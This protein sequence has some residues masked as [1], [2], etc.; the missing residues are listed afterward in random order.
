ML[1]FKKYLKD[2]SDNLSLTVAISSLVLTAGIGV[3]IETANMSRV[4]NKLQ[5]QVDIATLNAA[6]TKSTGQEDLNYST[7]AF[8]VMVEKGYSA[9][10]AKPEA[11]S[12]GTY[13]D[14]NV[15]IDY[16]GL[17]T[18]LLGGKSYKLKASAQ[19]TLPG[20]APLEMVLALDNTLSMSQ[21]GKM[22]ALKTGAGKIIDAVEKSNSGT[23][24]GLVPFARYVSVGEASG[25]WLD[26][27]AEY[28]T[29]RTW[30][31]ATHECDS[32][33]YEDKTEIRDGVAYTYEAEICNGRTTTYEPQ[34]TIVESR[35]VGCVGT[36]G[37]PNHLDP[38]SSN[39]RVMGL[40]NKQPYE[41]TGLPWDTDS[42]CPLPIRPLD[43]D[44]Y[45][46]GKHIN[47]MYPTDVTYIPLGLLWAERLLDRTIAYTQAPK[48]EAKQQ[49]M[50]LMSDGKNTSEIRDDQ[51]YED[52]LFSPPYIFY[53]YNDHNINV[54]SA[55]AD[56]SRLCERMKDKG[57]VIY[58]ISFQVD[59]SNAKTVL[60]DCASTPAH[61]YEAG[62]NDALIASFEHIGENLSTANVRLTR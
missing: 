57:I 35:F 16:E 30:Q 51:Y 47:E 58:T 40:L 41:A 11:V 50:I 56:T 23:L 21:G 61:A 1:N 10:I 44:Y 18:E 48:D 39:N 17:F 25:S 60:T 3:A 7:L 54:D 24:V 55:N 46:I 5:A 26:E 43:D 32:Y 42:F 14:V 9:E 37:R 62:D 13:L 15:T 45:E 12:D 52:H 38:V 34:S 49:V 20:I 4:Q 33:S 31:Q 22:G 36:S 8:D 28:D 27:P 59:D 53:D 29:D 2:T 6:S 19:S